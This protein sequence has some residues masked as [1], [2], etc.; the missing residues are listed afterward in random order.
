[1]EIF[2]R[3]WCFLGFFLLLNSVINAQVTHVTTYQAGT[4]I[5]Y[6]PGAC[7]TELPEAVGKI[8]FCDR[9]GNLGVVT[10]S[11]GLSDRG[12][13]KMIENNWNDDEVFLTR[14]GVSI[15]KTDGS[16]DNF[17]EFAAPR[18]TPN[19]G[20][21]I[22]TQAMID[23]QGRLLFRHGN[24]VG[25]HMLDL[26]SKEFS[27]F[28]YRNALGNS[29]NL[30]TSVFTQKTGTDT[31][32]VLAQSGGTHHLYKLYGDSLEPMGILPVSLGS[33]PDTDVFKFHNGYLYFGTTSGLHKIH[34]DDFSDY[35]VYGAEIFPV[36]NVQGFLFDSDD[37]IWLAVSTGSDG[38]IY[39]YKPTEEELYIYQNQN[40]SSINLRFTSVAL[41]NDGII[42]TVASNSS[43]IYSLN[44][45]PDN[46]QW[47]YLTMA[48]IGD[49]GFPV[50][51]SP[52]DVYNY[53]GKIYFV[54][55]DFSTSIPGNWEVLIY[56]NGNWQGVTDDEP[57]NISVKQTYRYQYSYPTDDG[58]WWF[59]QNDGGVVNFISNDESFSKA[60]NMGSTSAFLADVDGKPV[61]HQSIP[62]KI[63]L[64]FVYNF[65]D[66]GTNQ[67]VTIRRYKD[68]VWGFDRPGRR[69]FVWKNNKLVSE[70]ALDED[71]YSSY[72][73]FNVDTEGN[74]WFASLVNNEIVLKKFSTSTLTTTT[75][76]T[77]EVGFG[78]MR[79]PFPMPEGKMGFPGS[80]GLLVFDG[81]ESF[82]RFDNTNSNEFR[83]IVNAVADTTGNIYLFAHDAARMISIKD[84]LS[85]TPVIDLLTLEG[86]NGVIP[87]VA[88][89]R[90]GGMMFDKQ[91]N[92]WGHGSNRW[93]KVT[94]DEPVIP[95][96]NEGETY[97]I[98]GRVFLDINENNQFDAGEEYVN[99]KVSLFGDG[100]QIDTY[101]D[102]QGRYF[103]S[104]LP[105]TTDYSV[106]LPNTS[107]LVTAP[108]RQVSFSAEAA[109]S[110][111][112]VDDFMLKSRNINSLMVKSSAKQ[113]AWGFIREGFENT[114]TT[115][116]GNISYTKTFHEID[117]T[118][119]FKNDPDT[120][121]TELP[122]IESL[123]VYRI[124]P[125]GNTHVIEHIS[126]NPRNHRWTLNMDPSFY[127]QT[128]VET[129]FEVT[130]D[131]ISKTV[132]FSIGSIEPLD[133]WIIE[134]RTGLFPA[135]S[136][137][138]AIS[139]GVSS[140]GSPDIGDDAGGGSTTVFLIPVNQDDNAAP[141]SDLTPYIDP[142]DVYDDPPYIDP[143]DIYTDGPY[144]TPI[145]SSY[146]PND[147]LVSPGVPDALNLTDIDKKWLTYTVR[148]QNDGNFSAKDVYIIDEMDENLDLNSLTIVEHSH[149]MTVN[150]IELEDGTALKFN[151]NDIY[152]DYSSND[153]E[154][155]QGHVKF[156]VKAKDDIALETIVSNGAAIYFDQNPP[157]ITNTVQNKFMELHDLALRIEPPPGGTV[158]LSAAGEYFQDETISVLA[159]ASEHYSFTGWSI[160]QDTI[161]T[162]AQLDLTMPNNDVVL[163][164]N[165]AIDRYNIDAQ[166]NDPTFGT[167]EGGGEYDYGT[168]ATLTA[169][170]AT[171]YDFV[172]WGENDFV[173]SEEPSF[174]ITVNEDRTFVAYFEPQTFMITAMADNPAFGSVD[175]SGEYTFGETATLTATPNQGYVFVEWLED[176]EMVSQE[177]TYQF[178]VGSARE[179]TA[180]FAAETSQ[181][182]LAEGKLLINNPVNDYLIIDNISQY[183]L[184]Q[185]FN[186]S[187]LLISEIQLSQENQ[188]KHPVM[189]WN[190]GVYV[191]RLI[192]DEGKW[193]QA[194]V[195]KQ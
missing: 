35:T 88:F 192:D 147:K 20:S 31:T 171:G 182:E 26:Q 38:A 122:D 28:S 145:F 176:D 30:Y 37:N 155:S 111:Y 144:R 114:F 105:L 53:L 133:T 118:Y 170:P 46:L 189:D 84:P 93:A 14:A 186:S 195:I 8:S 121:E 127:T 45:D 72:Y 159:S 154:A 7:Q 10:A 193:N 137:G 138:N 125:I 99:Q 58:M 89:Y 119:I 67:T 91:G 152:L 95:F 12:V 5:D 104:Y 33:A 103:F 18:A 11:Y 98:V 129:P 39:H 134:I 24:A 13:Q 135:E 87:Y 172:N 181:E 63:D 190:P 19:S 9:N 48:D 139:Y 160:E 107:T 97:G 157:I 146:D 44:P 82:V 179:L 21:A 55:N 77:G 194:K 71:V 70:Y 167:I 2:R 49:L 150:Q 101:T 117:L 29:L 83:N 22:L 124:D 173:I 1:M 184:I 62:K 180:V 17:P 115:A 108:V 25:L 41:D 92:L 64:P 79:T 73:N 66:P 109:D 42:W 94:L 120:P 106:S 153:L 59:N 3:F 185:I 16:W 164:A 174:S 23:S 123:T 162:D 43:G 34:P 100:V 27:T 69:I 86:T 51:Y 128:P 131:D 52:N 132:S 78:F 112:E 163:V 102:E 141:I 149:P 188:W 177:A 80:S 165:F 60:Y 81:N 169:T 161:S 183:Q 113:G 151:F 148:F 187:G 158:N 54:T 50:T 68:Q 96:L 36:T 85:E 175:G 140:V 74:A 15:R 156:M 110:N 32:Y 142:S 56:D 168:E 90:P 76:E 130:T 166:A 40:A 4:K 191:V 126:I 6:F 178:T 143:D 65:Q 116:I 61:I 136:T 57:D 75:Y 47:N